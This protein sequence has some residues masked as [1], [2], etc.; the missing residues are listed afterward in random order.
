MAFGLK[1]AG[2]TKK[3]DPIM[4]KMIETTT[5]EH[6]KFLP[7]HLNYSIF[8]QHNLTIISCGLNSSMFNIVFGTLDCDPALWYS[9]IQKIIQRFQ[10]QPFAWWIPPSMKSADL[11]KAL[12]DQGFLI[13]TQEHAMICDLVSYT[14]VPFKTNI[15][16]KQVLTTENLKDFI[17]ILEPYDSSA[18]LFYEKL[19]PSILDLDEK[20]FVGYEKNAPI[21]IGILFENQDISGIFSLLTHEDQRGKGFG[22]DM[23]FYLLNLSKSCGQKYATLSASSD[24]GYR[25]YE[26]LGFQALGEFECFEYRAT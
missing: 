21:T 3:A 9:E 10:G 17:K 19:T 23:M 18:R 22:T 7:K 16:I 1:N 20:L 11:S 15:S 12:L 5:L 24:S 26:R 13:E 14:E 6:F 8:Q 25:I 2:M 4:L